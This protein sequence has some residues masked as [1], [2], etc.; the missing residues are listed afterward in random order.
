MTGIDGNLLNAQPASTYAVKFVSSSDLLHGTEAPDFNSAA[1]MSDPDPIKV[2]NPIEKA[3]TPSGDFKEIDVSLPSAQK[4]PANKNFSSSIVLVPNDLNSNFATNSTSTGSPSPGQHTN[5]ASGYPHLNQNNLFQE[6]PPIADAGPAQVVNSGSTVTL[7][8]SNSK[9]ENGEIVS[10]S[11]E[12]VPT[13]AK[14][15]LS[16]VNS[17][18][19]KFVAPHV[20]GDTILRFKLTVT[21]NVGQSGQDTVNILDKPNLGIHSQINPGLETILA[22]S[23]NSTLPAGEVV[24]P[25]NTKSNSQSL[26]TATPTMSPPLT[27]PLATTRH[28]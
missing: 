15:T 23:K 13:N 22:A 14:I 2:S 21:D 8:G 5:F 24:I 26:T 12:Q 28:R 4:E 10:Y 6:L 19:W 16:G 17:P 25:S 3:L 20:T 11:W 7:N 1:S 27:P 18:I 9:A